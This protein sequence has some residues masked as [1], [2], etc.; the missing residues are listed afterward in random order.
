VERGEWL[1]H[2][3]TIA[4]YR[5][6]YQV[7]D[8]D[9]GQPLGPYPER[10]RVGHR[11]Y[12]IAAASL[13][14]LRGNRTDT[15]RSWGRLAADRYRTLDTD[16]QARIA[17]E[18]AERLGA[19]WLG[20]VRDPAADADQPLYRDQLA[21]ILVKHGHLDEPASGHGAAQGSRIPSAPA[22]AGQRQDRQSRTAQPRPQPAPA[23]RRTEAP[24]REP[25][26]P[27]QRPPQAPPEQPRG[28]RPGQ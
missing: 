1:R 22:R 7:T 10:G 2:L 12:W 15:D 21:A 28:P 24:R 13:L 26:A 17:T 5:D 19:H 11:A 16:E 8:E 27:I 20:N 9:P 18:L 6:Q 3:A 4:A 23:A 14:A 25:T